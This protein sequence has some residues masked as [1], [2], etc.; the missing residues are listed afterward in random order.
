MVQTRFALFPL[1]SNHSSFSCVMSH[2]QSSWSDFPPSP[3]P[4]HIHSPLYP[5]TVPNNHTIHGQKD[6]LV[7]WLH[8]VLLQ[9]MSP[10][11]LW[12]LAVQRSHLFSNHQGEQVSVQ[13][14]ILVRTSQLRLCLRKSMTDKAW[15]LLLT[16]NSETS[17]CKNLLLY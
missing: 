3:L 7:D 10:T 17:H 13:C 1:E 16:Q 2:A 8:K 9:G 6:S 5:R 11:P 12:R 14:I 4:R 15:E